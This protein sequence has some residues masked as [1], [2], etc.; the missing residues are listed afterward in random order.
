M[1]VPACR[2][3]ISTELRVFESSRIHLFNKNAPAIIELRNYLYYPDPKA[4][5]SFSRG[6]I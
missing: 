2:L 6:G 4:S 1:D 5:L 3:G